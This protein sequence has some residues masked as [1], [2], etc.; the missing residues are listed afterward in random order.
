MK[1]ETQS[2]ARM[3]PHTTDKAKSLRFS[4]RSLRKIALIALERMLL[5][6]Y[7]TDLLDKFRKNDTQT[8]QS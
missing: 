4:L 2:T 1:N 6:V 8:R 3:I 7:M 5:I